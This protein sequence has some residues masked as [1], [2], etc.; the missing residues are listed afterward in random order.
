M[1]RR[2]KWIEENEEEVK[3]FKE[4]SGGTDLLKPGKC[5]E[6]LLFYA[7]IHPKREKKGKYREDR[8]I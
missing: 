8:N 2:P 6:C 3:G 1:A 7:D 5:L 4:G